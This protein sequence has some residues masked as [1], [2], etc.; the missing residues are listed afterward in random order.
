KSESLPAMMEELGS[1]LAATAS[2]EKLAPLLSEILESKHSNCLPWQMA[3]AG[4]FGEGLRSRGFASRDQ[5]LIMR[6]AGSAGIPAGD[7]TVAQFAGRDAGAPG[8]D[9]R[10]KLEGLF[11]RA[12]EIAIDGAQPLHS[13]LAAVGLLR[14]ADYTMASKT[15]T[16]LIDPQQPSELQTSAIRA[17]S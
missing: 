7:N 13:R 11:Q 16:T 6:I 17:F 15:L 10:H 4:G 1:M 9:L 8:E 3:A 5:S 2:A 14:Q 12:G